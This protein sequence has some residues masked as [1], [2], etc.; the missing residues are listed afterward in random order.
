M[1][2][3]P[4]DQYI[5]LQIEADRAARI[6]AEMVVAEMMARFRR[7]DD[8][9]DD[10]DLAEWGVVAWFCIRYAAVMAVF[11]WVAFTPTGRAAFNALR[12]LLA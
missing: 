12:S 11:C 6:H 1:N 10:D 2:L 3:R 4:I 9:P 8:V 5:Q 7:A